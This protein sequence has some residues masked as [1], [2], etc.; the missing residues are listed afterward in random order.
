MGKKCLVPLYL[1]RKPRNGLQKE[2]IKDE[3]KLKT[4]Y[5]IDRLICFI[6]TLLVSTT[7]IERAFSSN[8][9]C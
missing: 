5:L 9:N 3:K 8:K 2:L 6:L 4:Y 1:G 7:I